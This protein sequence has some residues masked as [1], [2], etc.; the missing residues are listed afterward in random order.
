MISLVTGFILDLLFGDPYWMPHPVRG[1]GWVIQKLEQRLR[2]GEDSP[3]RQLWKG[4]VLAVSVCLVSVLIP[5]A[6]LL[7]AYRIHRYLGIA[8][9]AFMCYQLLA[10]KC[11]KVESMKV[12]QALKAGD[13]KGARTAVSMIVGRDTAVLDET[14]I[15]KAA[16]ETVA[17]NASDG[18]IAPLLYM[19]LG[20][21]L[22]GFFY[23]A[24]NTM[25]SMIGYKN[26]K[27]LHFG[28]AAARMDDILN[29]LPSRISGLCMTAVSFLLGMDGKNAWRILRRDGRKHDSPN[30]AQTE[31]ACAG[32]L[33]IQLAGDAWYFGHKKEKPTI[34]DPIRPVCAEDIRLANRLLYGSAVLTLLVVCAVRAGVGCILRLAL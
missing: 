23:K 18:S 13:V 15:T 21:P 19:A 26:E 25:D 20:G 1:I 7:V 34:G 2:S 10:T 22:L 17:E 12:Y 28:R 3:G 31:A 16:V 11:L 30:S 29:Y 8:L 9:G 14:G 33:Q 4:A 6:L 32:A 5:G 24:V 27:Y